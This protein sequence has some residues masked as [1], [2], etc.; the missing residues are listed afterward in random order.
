MDVA[1]RAGEEVLNKDVF[2]LTSATTFS[3]AEEF[4]YNLKNLR[5]AVSIGETTGG[6]A[7]PVV[8]RRLSDHLFATIPY[9]K[10]INPISHTTWEGT[11]V[12]PDYPM[13]AQHALVAAH[14]MAATRLAETTTDP[15]LAQN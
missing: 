6:G 10:A 15:E 13:P 14:R 11:G 3:A 4:S 5:R 8:S 7:H 1:S 12:K 9:A 2:V